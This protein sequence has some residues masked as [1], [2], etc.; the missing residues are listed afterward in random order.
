MCILL[1]R[2]LYLRGAVAVLNRP[3]SSYFPQAVVLVPTGYARQPLPHKGARLPGGRL[4]VF[5][6]RHT[7]ARRPAALPFGRARRCGGLPPGRLRRPAP[8][9]ARSFGRTAL[10]ARESGSAIALLLCAVS[11][12][13]SAFM[14]ASGG[15]M[16]TRL[17]DRGMHEPSLCKARTMQAPLALDAV[18]L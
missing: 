1:P 16:H 17:G 2:N 5:I 14:S 13:P 8:Q 4:G 15:G 11:A 10:A 18:L 9:G 6:A 12:T 7:S 3:N